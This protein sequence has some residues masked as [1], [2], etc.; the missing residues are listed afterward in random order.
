MAKKELA[1]WDPDGIFPNHLPELAAEPE[2][3]Q[4]L[5]LLQP[6]VSAERTIPPSGSLPRK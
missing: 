3:I 5:Q 6:E 1:E 4:I 2:A